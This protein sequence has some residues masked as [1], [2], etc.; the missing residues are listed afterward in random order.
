MTA[1]RGINNRPLA[2]RFAERTRQEPNG[3]VVWTGSRTQ[4]GYGQIS[5]G[6]GVRRRRHLAHRLSWELTNGPIPDGV[7]VCHKCDN[8]PCVNPSHLFVGSARDNN[9]DAWTKGRNKKVSRPSFWVGGACQRGHDITDPKNVMASADG[10]RCRRCK[11][12]VASARLRSRRAESHA[13]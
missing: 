12:A 6:A 7:F 4:Q 2:I 9:R 3:C 11:Y 1:S 13:R 8:P 5:E 10:Q